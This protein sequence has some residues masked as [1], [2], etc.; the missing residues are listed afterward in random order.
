MSQYFD[1]QSSVEERIQPQPQPQPKSEPRKRSSATSPTG[2][3]VSLR[4]TDEII[5]AC[6][7]I[8]TETFI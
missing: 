3:K 1:K 7:L 6:S 4:K 5:H 2:E 8:C